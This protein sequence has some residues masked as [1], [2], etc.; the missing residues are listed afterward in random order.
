MTAFE[1][2]SRDS[3]AIDDSVKFVQNKENGQSGQTTTSLQPLQFVSWVVPNLIARVT[4]S[5]ESSCRT[6]LVRNPVTE[7]ADSI[8]LRLLPGTL[9]HA[10]R[11]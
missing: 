6:D 8:C 9:S 2:K 4:K 11:Q 3:G 10:A 7:T 5:A 1:T